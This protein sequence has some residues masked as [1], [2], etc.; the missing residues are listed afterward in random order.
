M[1]QT[2][3]KRSWSLI[4]RATVSYMVFLSAFYYGGKLAAPTVEAADDLGYRFNTRSV[5][6]SQCTTNY[7]SYISSAVSDYNDNTDLS[8]TLI[9][10]SCT[11]ISYTQGDYGA[12]PWIAVAVPQNSPTRPCIDISDG[13]VTGDCNKTTRKASS[14]TIYFNDYYGV[15][16]ASHR[17]FAMRHEMGHVF[18]LAHV[19]CSTSSVMK[20]STDCSSLPST[21]RTHEKNLINSW[22]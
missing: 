5:S 11:L 10:N 4:I 3:T 15:L 19:S 18:G 14:A 17:N 6:V 22:Y 7:G 1:R 2:V 20:E 21:L 13:D 8:M 9:T 16:P 12:T